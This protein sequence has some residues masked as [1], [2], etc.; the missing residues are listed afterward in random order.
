MVGLESKTFATN[1]TTCYDSWVS[2]YYTELMHAE[3][4]FHYGDTDDIVFNST[5]L[6]G[7]VAEHL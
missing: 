4:A 5:K 1:A 2:F 3:I 6:I 7:S